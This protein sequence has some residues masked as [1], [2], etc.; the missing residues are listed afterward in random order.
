[1]RDSQHITPKHTLIS[2]VILSRTATL[3]YILSMGL[4]ETFCLKFADKNIN[5]DQRQNSPLL[6]LPKSKL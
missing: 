5:D 6:C 3:T 2:P 4:N 1:M